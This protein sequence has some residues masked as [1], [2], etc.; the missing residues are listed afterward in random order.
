MVSSYQPLRK[1]YTVDELRTLYSSGNQ[2]LWPLPELFDE[3][4]L[5]FLDIG[6]LP[7]PFY[8]KENPFSEDKRKL[9]EL[10]FFEPKLSFSGQIACASCHDPEFA[11]ADG[12][13]V[14]KG[15]SLRNGNRNSPTVFNIA[16]AKHLFWD[17]RAESLE[18]QVLG[19]ITNPVE[20]HTELHIAVENIRK[21]SAYK[22]FFRKAFGS[23]SVNI[24][25]ISQAIA[26]YER[27]LVTQHTRFDEFV[28]GTAEA[29]SDSEVRGLHLFRTKA[30]CINCH[31]TPYFSDQKFHNLGMTNYGLVTEDLG[32]YNV[33]F[34]NE[35]VGKFKTPT[36]RE[37]S[38][39][40]PYFH[41]G[42]VRSLDDL[43]RIYDRGMPRDV[44]GLLQKSDPKF[45]KKSDMIKVLNL[46]ED[47]QRDL[48]NFLATLSSQEEIVN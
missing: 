16:F 34:R 23:D 29:F 38:R 21:M 46:N 43:V 12:R 27:S 45:P 47:E 31:N 19:P 7:E 6:K 18:E 5:D 15:V 4:K 14:S 20:M 32:R 42:L 22:I 28:S 25:K 9:G 11:F 35:D 30:K 48:V 39:T 37:V 8:P 36:L 26:T 24:R 17:G 2:S 10:L 13:R 1:G 33:T 41:Q 3:A 40:A 44:P